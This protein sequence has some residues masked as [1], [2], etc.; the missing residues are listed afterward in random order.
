MIVV[1][2]KGGTLVRNEFWNL[3]G[4]RLQVVPCFTY[5]GIN[6]TWQLPLMQMAKY[7]AVKGKRVL[8]SVLSKLYQ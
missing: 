3:G 2:K 8:I 1:F 5:V 6:Y 4:A 7:Q